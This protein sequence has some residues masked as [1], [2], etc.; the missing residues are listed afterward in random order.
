MFVTKVQKI[1]ETN[2]SQMKLISPILRINYQT[3]QSNEFYS[4]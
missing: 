1:I 2:K 4:R 3:V